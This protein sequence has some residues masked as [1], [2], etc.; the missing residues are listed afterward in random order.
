MNVCNQLNTEYRLC[1]SIFPVCHVCHAC[2]I[3][4]RQSTHELTNPCQ[5]SAMP[6]RPV[7]IAIQL[8]RYQEDSEGFGAVWRADTR[9]TGEFSTSIYDEV[10]PLFPR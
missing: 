10:G 2:S 3:D 8:D 5:H 9:Q 1:V 4:I 6:F 7:T